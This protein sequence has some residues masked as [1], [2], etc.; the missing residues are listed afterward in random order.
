MGRPDFAPGIRLDDPYWG[1]GG[2]GREPVLAEF[3]NANPPK[4]LVSFQTH[5]AANGVDICRNSEFGFEGNAFVALF[6]D[7][8]A[9][10]WDWDGYQANY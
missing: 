10:S 3:P 8:A 5:V 2:H 6:G 4:S 9:V 7:I 1:E